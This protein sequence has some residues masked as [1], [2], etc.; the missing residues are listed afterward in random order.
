MLSCT[1]ALCSYTVH[2]VQVQFDGLLRIE[3]SAEEVSTRYVKMSG[4][5]ARGHGGLA[6]NGCMIVHN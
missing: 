6:P 4:A 3:R 2:D 5:Y 1:S